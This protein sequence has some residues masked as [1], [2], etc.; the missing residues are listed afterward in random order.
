MLKFNQIPPTAETTDVDPAIVRMLAYGIEDRCIHGVAEVCASIVLASTTDL[1]EVEA[2]G[3]KVGPGS[4]RRKSD[5]E[6]FVGRYN[7]MVGALLEGLQAPA[8]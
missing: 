1:G 4:T 8:T 5:A 2:I 3:Q 7:S 6:C